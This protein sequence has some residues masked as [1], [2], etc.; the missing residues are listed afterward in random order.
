MEIE[1]HW[2][3]RIKYNNMYTGVSQLPQN[4]LMEGQQVR[5]INYNQTEEQNMNDEQMGMEPE[6]RMQGKS[7]GRKIQNLM[8]IE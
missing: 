2:G 8:E 6:Y 5:L 1:Q 7:E 4:E 3:K